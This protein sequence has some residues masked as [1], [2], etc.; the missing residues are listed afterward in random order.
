MKSSPLS[1]SPT[2]RLHPRVLAVLA[3][4]LSLAFVSQAH[5]QTGGTG[6]VTGP[7]PAT[8]GVAAGLEECLSSAAQ[9]ERSA[10]FSGEMTAIAGTARMSMRVEVEERMSGE[11]SFH[12]I[13]GAGLGVWRSSDP[14][15]KVY[16]YLKQV[17][18]LAS[19]A[20][21]RAVVDFR[22]L[23]AKGHVIK[24]AERLTPRCAQLAAPSTTET[25]FTTPST[26]SGAS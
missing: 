25:P 23:N 10:T 6:T 9:A 14:R 15:V 7:A 1:A 26:P 19:P 21:Y 24:R 12:T 20:V 5:G 18:N 17:S 13:T 4:S 22:W 2:R 8:T 3:C 16:K 11:G